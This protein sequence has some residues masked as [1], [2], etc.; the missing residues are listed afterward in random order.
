MAARLANSGELKRIKVFLL[1][2]LVGSKRLHIMREENSTKAYTDLVWKTAARLGYAKVFVNEETEVSDDHLS[3]LSRGVPAVD[4]I[5]LNT[6]AEY[7]HTS[8]DTLDK[9]SAKS[10]AIVGHTIL[11]S[12]KE[13]QKK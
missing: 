2:D 7:W 8:Q 9:V 5:D 6:S 11:E 13:L 3:F 10:L 12:V 1:A 4:V